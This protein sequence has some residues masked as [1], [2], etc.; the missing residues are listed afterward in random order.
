[1]KITPELFD[2]RDFFPFQINFM[3]YFDSKKPCKIFN[4]PFA[5]ESV[6]IV[7]TTTDLIN[8]LKRVNLFWHRRESKVVNLPVS[9]LLKK[10]CIPCSVFV[11]QYL[12]DYWR[13]IVTC[14]K[15]TLPFSLVALLR[16]VQG[17]VLGS[18]NN[19]VNLQTR[20]ISSGA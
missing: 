2:K 16:P 11:L 17:W 14:R 7:R 6:L 20:V 1:M 3:L 13:K 18:S 19:R 8:M 10:M 4:A 9:F 15:L 12:I 5:S